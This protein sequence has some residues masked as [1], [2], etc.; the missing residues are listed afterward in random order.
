MS[1]LFSFQLQNE[2]KTHDMIMIAETEHRCS[3]VVLIFNS[4]DRH[5]ARGRNPTPSFFV[6]RLPWG[7]LVSRGGGFN[8][9]TSPLIFTLVERS[10]MAGLL[11]DQC[12]EQAY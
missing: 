2:P 12:S 8:P 9:P 11:K 3:V 7:T 5:K 1:F 10:L 4:M 6:E